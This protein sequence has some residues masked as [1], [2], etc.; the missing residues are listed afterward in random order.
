MSIELIT[1][2]VKRYSP[3]EQESEAVNYLVAWMNANGF[4]AS[5]DEAGNAVGVRGKADAPN[6]LM[7]LG[8]ID[9]VPGE[10]AVRVEDGKLYGRGSVDAKGPLC[11]FASATAQA[12]IPENWRVMVVGAVEEETSSSKGARSIADH[13]T[14]TLCIIGEPSGADRITLG[15]KGRLVVEYTYTRTMTHTAHPEPSAGA[16]GIQFWNNL[17]KWADA[18]NE[19]FERQFDKILLNLRNIHTGSDGL[20]EHVQMTIGFRLPLRFT[21]GEV[22]EHISQYVIPHS[23]IRVTGAEKAYISDKNSMLVRGML[24]TLRAQGKSPGFVYKTGTSDMN[25]VGAVWSCPMIAYG[26]GDSS[27]DH[28]PTEHLVLEEYEQAVDVVRL[29]VEN[30][31][32]MGVG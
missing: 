24:A 19:N 15:Y 11:T 2:L 20:Y 4:T 32:N 27:L 31:G 28:T 23:E 18:E 16:V 1:E 8:H 3:S 25:V 26:P 6:L 29:F 14:P 21:P 13:F 10:I 22:V 7:L 5:V 9:T 30:L 12:K 17:Q